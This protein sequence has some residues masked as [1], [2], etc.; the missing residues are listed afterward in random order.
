MLAE[1]GQEGQVSSIAISMSLISMSVLAAILL[2]YVTARSLA[3][4]GLDFD[5]RDL[6]VVGVLSGVIAVAV[7]AALSFLQATRRAKRAQSSAVAKVDALERNLQAAE[8]IFKAEPQVLIFWEDSGEPHLIANQ[9]DQ[10]LGV[11]TD[12][13]QLLKFRGWLEPDSASELEGGLNALFQDGGPFNVMLKTSAGAF[14]EADGRAAGGRL[15]LKFRDLAG[16]RLELAQI[17]EQHSKLSG[18]IKANRVLLESIPTPV[19]FRGDDGK[20]EWVN[21]AY[22]SAVGAPDPGTVTE[23]QI[24]LLEAR[25]RDAVE[26]ALER[27]ET[28]RERLHTIVGGERRT[29]DVIGVPLGGSNAGFAVDV[30]ALETVKSDLDRHIAAHV[31][32]LDRV[33]TAV[34][35]FGPDQRLTFYNQA[36]LDV[37]GL[38]AQWL[39]SGPKDGEILDRLRALRI[40]PEQADYRA[41]RAKFL[42]CYQ[43]SEAREDWWYLPDGRSIHVVAEQR[44]DGGV[45]YLFDDATERIALESRYNS[46]FHVQQ[47]TLENLTEGVAVFATDGRLTLFNPAFAVIWKL[48]INALKKRPHIDDIIRLCSVLHDDNAVWG[49]FK[50]AVTAIYDHRQDFDGQ[51]NRADDSV[52]DYSCQPLPDGGTLLTF[53]DVTDSKRVEKVLIERNEALEAANRLKNDFIQ[54]VSYELRTP[55]TN[56][57]GFSDLLADTKIGFLN[58]KQKEY[59]GD[60]RAS[61]ATLLS[62]IND[63]LDLATIDAGALELNLRT[64]K[65]EDVI[66]SAALGVRERLVRAKLGLDIRV[67]QTLSEFL[68][69]GTRITQ[70]LYNLLSNAIGFSEEGNRISLICQRDG[71]MIAFSIVDQG[72]GIP[73]EYHNAVFERFE[74]RSQGSK[75]RGAGLGLSIVKSL[76]E[77]HGGDVLLRSKPGAGTSITVRFPEFGTASA[78]K[79]KPLQLEVDAES[80]AADREGIREKATASA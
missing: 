4:A 70:I 7:L 11:P 56:I 6:F 62:I 65:V 34:A 57:I 44:P 28:Y 50:R 63:I 12:A 24:E 40:L 33:S 22:V 10:N 23:Q 5:P 13:G 1:R 58:E 76:A 66:R 43:I 64:V 69:D 71:E 35:I 21:Q 36:Y 38:E 9:L 48:N 78:S 49:E 41:W 80:G 29:F 60:I 75:H 47:E 20:I 2:I 77:L 51:L 25:Q 42:D 55:L 68:G 67:E 31:R 3:T 18:I 14:L 19:W 15:I 79:P 54:N 32:T 46:L 74:S 37:W 45:T 26:T 30:A 52:I 59:L 27:G 53:V 39:E 8:A 17:C 61:G 72:C 16:R 73:E